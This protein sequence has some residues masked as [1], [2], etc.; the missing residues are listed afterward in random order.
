MQTLQR[1][2]EPRNVIELKSFLGLLS[3]YSHFLP[4]LSTV[5]SPS[6]MLLGKC[7]RWCWT[8]VEKAAFTKAKQLLLSSK[9]LT[10]FNQSLLLTLACDASAYGIGA[11]L[12]H[13]MANGSE[14][15]IG[16]VS[17]TLSKLEKGYPQIEKEALACVFG[18]RRF[19][20]YL[21]GYH[22]LFQTN[23]RPCWHC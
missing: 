23:H 11:I 19:H 16:F 20:D 2:P 1:A 7:Q 17:R 3:Y 22:F 8:E 21:Y 5:L 15:P 18:G 13:H 14:K 9:V 6:Y 10:H 4:N 12:S